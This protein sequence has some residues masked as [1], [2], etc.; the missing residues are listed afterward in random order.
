MKPDAGRAGCSKIKER[1]RKREKDRGRG[2]SQPVGRRKGRDKWRHED[3][4]G[5]LSTRTDG[6][7]DKQ[8]EENVAAAD[9]QKRFD[10][11]DQSAGSAVEPPWV[12]S[13]DSGA[14][15]VSDRR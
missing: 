5:E 2:G 4:A 1:K 11:S 3:G 14:G 8:N 13:S 12:L 15:S 7:E 6:Q 9:Q 10:F